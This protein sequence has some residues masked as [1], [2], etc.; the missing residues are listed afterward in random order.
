MKL[1]KS[2]ASQI[3]QI[4]SLGLFVSQYNEID[5][6]QLN[7]VYDISK[8]IGSKQYG[9]HIH[10]DLQNKYS[11]YAFWLLIDGTVA[12]TESQVEEATDNYIQLFSATNLF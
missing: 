6:R 11:S 5:V 1:V 12:V 10:P 8:G 3:E 2:T 9:N 4:K 7:K